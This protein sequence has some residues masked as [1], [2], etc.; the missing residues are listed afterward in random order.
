MDVDRTHGDVEDQTEIDVSQ[1]DSRLTPLWESWESVSLE[2]VIA[3][4]FEDQDVF[5]DGRHFERCR[6]LRCVVYVQFGRFGFRQNEITDSRFIYAGPA[7][8]I[9]KMIREGAPIQ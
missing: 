1:R 2:P 9:V 8:A 4:T 3:Q 7:E 5:L 6:I